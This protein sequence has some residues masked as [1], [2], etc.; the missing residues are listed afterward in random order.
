MDRWRRQDERCDNR[1][2]YYHANSG[3]GNVYEVHD[4][5]SGG[6]TSNGPD[7]RCPSSSTV[8]PPP[9]PAWLYKPG[10]E[11]ALT[12]LKPSGS[13]YQ[14]STSAQL[15]EQVSSG[16]GYHV[17]RSTP[18]AADRYPYYNRKPS[19]IGIHVGPAAGE[20][21]YFM[22]PTHGSP[23]HPQYW[24]QL[25]IVPPSTP[26]YHSPAQSWSQIHSPY[27]QY[28]RYDRPSPMVPSPGK[29]HKNPET[30]GSYNVAIDPATQVSLE[31]YP[32]I[33][34]QRPQRGIDRSRLVPESYTPAIR[35]P[36]VESHE[37]DT[38]SSNLRVP[39]LEQSN[40]TSS[41]RMDSARRP[42]HTLEED[43][44][45]KKVWTSKPRRSR[46]GKQRVLSSAGR[47]HAKAIRQFPGGACDGCRRKKTKARGS[48]D[49]VCLRAIL[50]L[51]SAFTG[52]Q[53]IWRR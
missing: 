11:Q 41:R 50:T 2:G 1:Q 39:V 38:P 19:R 17:P 36:F 46:T 10:T 16:P 18:N 4:N 28:L 53:R 42:P 48:A 13:A 23:Q 47:D 12:Q 37:Y 5:G 24:P 8:P 3:G 44:A 35:R 15:P 30:L 34:N 32:D 22:Q 33:S 43:R 49:T 25:P 31:G 20:S 51:T 9:V 52:Y 27:G 26:T 29:F 6:Q 45:Q 14:R 21:T 40:S 7:L